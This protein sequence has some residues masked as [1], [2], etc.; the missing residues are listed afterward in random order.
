M[1]AIEIFSVLV[2]Y[3]IEFRVSAAKWAS[4][5]LY[6]LHGFGTFVH[7]TS[8]YTTCLGVGIMSDTG[9]LWLLLGIVM[10]TYSHY[11]QMI[12]SANPSLSA[13]LRSI[14]HT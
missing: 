6:V 12:R 14:S 13:S 8:V 1:I 11:V 10:S 3:E 4:L 7:L 2:I 5:M 9:C